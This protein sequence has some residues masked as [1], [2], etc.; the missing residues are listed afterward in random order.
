MIETGAL[1]EEVKSIEDIPEDKRQELIIE[2]KT[3][4]LKS[5]LSLKDSLEL[6]NT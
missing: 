6:P 3:M 1:T 4:L 2:V 5:N